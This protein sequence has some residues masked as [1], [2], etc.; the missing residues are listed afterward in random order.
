LKSSI[1]KK[2]AD[3][4]Y[5][6]PLLIILNSVFLNN[7][8]DVSFFILDAIIIILALYVLYKF[9][10][11][12]LHILAFLVPFSFQTKIGFGAKLNFPSEI[13]CI[14]LTFYVFIKFITN[15][16]IPKSFLFHP[17]T[18]ILFIDILWLTITSFFSE[19]TDVSAKRTIVRIVYIVVYYYLF[20]ELFR[21]D[22]K[23]I[24]SIFSL[25]VLG[26]IYPIIHTTVVHSTLYFSTKGSSI[27]CQPFYNDHTIYGACLAMV[28]PFIIYYLLNTIT[29]KQ[30]KYIVFAT[31]I[32]GI[33]SLAV[34]LS[35]SRAAWIT[36]ILAFIVFLVI[37]FKVKAAYLYFVGFFFA[38]CLVVFWPNIK[39]YSQSNKEISHTDNIGMHFK[40]VV[41][42]NK[43]D[44]S[45]SERI[46]RWKCAWRMFLDKPVLGFGPGTYQFFYGQ[47]QQRADMTYISTFKGDKGHAHSEYLN[48]LSETGL[49]GALNFLAL[50]IL[51]GYYGV[52]NYYKSPDELNKYMSL[53]LFLGFFTYAIHAFFNGFL[54][55]DKIAMPFFVSITAIVSISIKLKELNGNNIAIKNSR[56]G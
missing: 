55:S 23:N 31:L 30:K 7:K 2:Y 43:A 40:S 46:N 18:I 35:Y 28:F 17:I 16:K 48:Y 22:L 3:L 54:E 38:T 37:K 44:M 26:M 4:L 27:A 13:I 15:L 52:T 24:V 6:I 20:N 19:L 25:H 41:N 56:L 51:T 50:I 33:F 9:K 11:Y 5:V 32:L 49:I 45:N 34:F 12:V 42:V 53:F 14:I 21:K 8:T 36:L 47:F 1:I 39:E 29:D 10:D